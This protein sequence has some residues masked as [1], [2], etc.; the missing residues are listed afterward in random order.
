MLVTEGIY[1]FSGS[2]GAGVWGANVYLLVGETLALVDTGAR[3]RANGIVREVVRLGFSLFGISNYLL[4]AR[5]ANNEECA[6]LLPAWCG[7][8]RSGTCRRTAP[9]ESR[10]QVDL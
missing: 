8:R 1:R 4:R 10:G 9:G 3:G 2:L 6:R 7:G 5:T